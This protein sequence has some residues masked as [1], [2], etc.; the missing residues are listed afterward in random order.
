MY[1]EIPRARTWH[2]PLCFLFKLPLFKDKCL[3]AFTLPFLGFLDECM[4]GGG[5][6]PAVSKIPS[7][8]EKKSMQ[9]K[10]EKMPAFLLFFPGLPPEVLIPLSLS[11]KPAIT[12]LPSLL[13]LALW[14]DLL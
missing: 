3:P 13:A 9:I 12:Q 4:C 14:W 11:Q 10:P 5:D 7:V 1:F 2:Q 8:T 6:L